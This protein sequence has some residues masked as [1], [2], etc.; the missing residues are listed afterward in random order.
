MN[1]YFFFLLSIFALANLNAQVVI[2]EYSAANYTD[3]DFQ[4]GPGQAYEDWIELY[5]T[6]ASAFDLSGYYLSDKINNLQKWQFPAGTSVPGN[7]H[8]LVLAS[9]E[10]GFLYGYN[11]TNFKLT[12][13][14]GDEYIILS[15]GSGAIMDSISLNYPN[16]AN[17]S[18]GRI[19]D[20]SNTWGIFD[21]PTEGSSNTGALDKY[22]DKVVF[23]V[24]PGA[25]PSAQTVTLST[26][27]P[28][29][30]IRYTTD[31]SS[32]TATSTLYTSPLN[33][34]ATT[35]IRART[36]SN[37][38]QVLS[39]HVETNTY[40]IN[41]GHSL[42][43]LSV[44]GNNLATLFNGSQIEPFGSLELFETDGSF[45][46]EATGEF[47]KHGND[48]W[49]YD[50][51]GVDFIA[52]DQF[53]INYALE[54]EIFDTK[55]RDEFQRV[56]LKCGASD[57]FPFEPGGAHIRDA[58]I[59]EMSQLGDLRLDERSNEFAVLYLNGQYWGVYDIRE[60]TD[61]SDFTTYY[62]DQDVPNIQYL[63]T[64]GG[65]WEEYGA[66]NAQDDWDD[67][68]DFVN[69]NNMTVPANYA[70]VDSIY[71]TGSLIDYFIL[72]GFV[73]CADWLNWNTGW[74]RGMDPA[75]DKKKWRYTLWDMDASFGHYINFTGIPNQSA[76]ADPCDPESLGNPGGQGHVPIWNKL[77][78]N[79]DFFADYI[80]RYAELTSTVFT[81]DSMHNL[82]NRMVSEIQPEM[83][84]HA[85]RWGGNYNTWLANVQDIHDF[86]DT[87]CVNVPAGLVNCNPEI[88]GPYQVVFNVDPPLAGEIQLSSLTPSTYPFTTTYF[89][90]V[91]IDIDADPF[92]GWDFDYWTI[93][94]DTI[95]PDTLSENA[96]LDISA[97]DSIVA[98]FKPELPGDTVTFIVV[99]P[100]SGTIDINGTNQSAFPHTEIFPNGTL[101]TLAANANAGF[102]FSNWSMTN[103]VA[104][105]NNTSANIAVN[106]TGNDT[107]YAYFDPVPVDT[108]VF[109][110]NPPG[111][112][113]LTINGTV[114]NTFP[115]TGIY[116]SGAN[117]NL[118]ATANA[119]FAF[120]NWVMSAHSGTPNNNTANITFTL[121]AN[122]TIYANFNPIVEDTIVYLVD[123]PGSGN[124]SLNGT[125]LSPLPFTS[126]NQTGSLMNIQATAN[127]NFIF[128]FWEASNNTIANTNNASSSFNSMA[129]DTVTAHFTTNL[130]D[131]LVVIM[132]P[133]GSATLNVG[134][135]I[136]TNTP[137]TGIYPVN[138][139]LA[140]EAQANSG[141][142]FNRWE[143]NTQVLP[144][145]NPLTSFVFINQ[146]TLFAYINAPTSVNDLG[147]DVASFTLFPTVNDGNFIIDYTL[148]EATALHLSIVNVE[149]KLVKEWNFSNEQAG[150]A[151][152][153]ELSFEGSDGLYLLQI[154]SDQT[155]AVE[156]L[157]KLSK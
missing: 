45:L 48:S 95:L 40:F 101:L 89:G 19:T 152:Q 107:I 80:N 58:Y 64:W 118:S 119:G 32:P 46:T 109:V 51:R 55:D 39:S 37:N 102:T 145:Y 126:I 131:T 27:E 96:F 44:C 21:N 133:N 69:N 140:I 121:G 25:Y 67:F 41:E 99:G 18:R 36:Y 141:N 2:N 7:G 86:I 81:C 143:L 82:L 57:N 148:N 3:V 110:V 135:D 16:Q 4:T 20:G 112:G 93:E 73:V 151:Y 5:N 136:I 77:Q 6:S 52:R 149:G 87:R 8:L 56:I 127:A 75:G 23:S 17:H 142:S 137:F 116:N 90:G 139:P 147:D 38:P 122:D 146:D 104:N 47:N 10:N 62:Y 12:Q 54:D 66:P 100:G 134:G 79:D 31:G 105:P 88:S 70:Y 63:K 154:S 83:Q 91:N 144:D 74:W 150:V 61:D 138:S 15:D 68:V 50:Q 157:M 59:Q 125:N 53:G 49:A 85:N 9:S 33:I 1:K 71:N 124:I 130:V 113:T 22:A 108:L 29:S 156:K 155:Q 24:A 128:S 14:R 97:D 35:V 72:N 65:T 60:K 34:S 120:G 28:N 43:I 78:T 115:F 26:T 42:K 129:N 13:T 153:K 123:P 92:A 98:H 106:L 114:Q 111:A 11:N 94:N 103:N 84:R 76:N 30:E 132:F 117:M